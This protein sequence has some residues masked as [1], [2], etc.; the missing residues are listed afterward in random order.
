MQS[1][2][3]TDR[4]PKLLREVSATLPAS[5]SLAHDD[6]TDDCDR[7]DHL[8]GELAAFTYYLAAVLELFTGVTGTPKDYFRRLEDGEDEDDSRDGS[9]PDV[10]RSRIDQLAGARTAFADNPRVAVA[11]VD[12]F[13]ADQWDSKERF[14]WRELTRGTDANGAAGG[15]GGRRRGQAARRRRPAS[16]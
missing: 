6:E 7:L 9:R 11:I 16:S 1:L 4:E 3:A 14:V 2:T 12:Q 13:R 15:G 5:W 10:G 8:R